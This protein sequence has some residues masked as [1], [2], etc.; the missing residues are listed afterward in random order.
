MGNKYGSVLSEEV[1]KLLERPD[2]AA[3]IEGE[4][5]PWIEKGLGKLVIPSEG[6]RKFVFA[7]WMLVSAVVLLTTG[8]VSSDQFIEAVKWIG[9]FFFGGNAV[10]HGKEIPGKMLDALAGFGKA[11]VGA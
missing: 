5:K 10:E 7:F 8:H 2:V 1:L 11:K 3:K 9:G 4:A 6:G